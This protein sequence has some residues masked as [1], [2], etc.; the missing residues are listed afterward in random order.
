MI[1]IRLLA[2]ALSFAAAAWSS[3]WA[4]A[5]PLER[6]LTE[7]SYE[8]KLTPYL[9][10][11][12]RKIIDSS[13]TIL[14]GT[15]KYSKRRK[16]HRLS[17][18]EILKADP[19]KNSKR[20]I[21][22]KFRH[23][24]DDRVTYVASKKIARGNSRA[25]N[26]FK[27]T[28]YPYGI[29]GSFGPGDCGIS[30]EIFSDQNYLILA[31]KNFE[32]SAMFSIN[33]TTLPFQAAIQNMLD[34]PNEPYGVSLSLNQMLAEDIKIKLLETESCSPLPIFKTHDSS[35]SEE[36]GESFKSQPILIFDN[37]EDRYLYGLPEEVINQAR[38][39]GLH[40]GRFVNAPQLTA[41][42]IG[43]KHLSLGNFLYA[44][45]SGYSGQI[46]SEQ[47]G[48]FSLKETAFEHHITPSEIS[49]EQ[50]LEL[51]EEHKQTEANPQQTGAPE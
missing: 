3:A 36:I 11:K 23:I 27:P 1:M 29:E 19:A 10:N 16:T 39:R 21:S 2:V 42:R 6:A 18:L 46:I 4:C 7:K 37:F 8:E 15:F 40:Q 28:S 31:D 34:D 47:N 30:L 51:L 32:I 9:A 24:D 26:W 38:E 13:E 20:R 22:V 49:V 35:T 5:P 33:E 44:R 14:I 50:M 41:C 48:V 43:Q 17:I 45:S 25:A 12:H